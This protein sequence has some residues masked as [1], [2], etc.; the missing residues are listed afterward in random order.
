MRCRT[1]RKAVTGFLFLFCTAS[2]VTASMVRADVELPSVIGDNMVLQRGQPLPVW[3]WAKPGEMIAVTFAGQSVATKTDKN[4]RWQVTLAKI[5]A[6]GPLQMAITSQSG[7]KV[8][9]KNILAGEVWVCSGQSNMEWPLSRA[10]DGRQEI[11]AAKFPKMRLFQIPKVR[12]D[13]PETNCPGQWK[14]CTPAT[15]AGF[16][17]VGYFFGRKLHEDLDV[18][19]GLIQSAWG[20]TPAELWT[21]REVLEADPA[22]K[23]LAGRGSKLYNAMIAPLIPFSIRGAVWYQGEANCSRAYQYRTLLPA[24]IKNWRDD[25]KRGDFPFGIV[26]LAPFRY[27]RLD[28]ACC[29]ELWEAQLMTVKNVPHTGLAV[30]VDIGNVRNI[31]PANKQDVGHRLAL[32]A[33]A[34]TYGKKD[35]VFSGPI[36]KSMTV[37]GRKIRLSFDHTGGGLSTLDGKPPSHF[38]IAGADEKFHPATAAI[39]GPTIVVSCDAVAKPVA[40]RY[41]W[42]DDAQPNLSNKAGLPASP[43][44]TDQWKGVTQPQQ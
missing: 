21:R 14:E 19:V 8:V 17:A 34:E 23:D 1:F 26:Q 24:M 28:P 39:D 6:G 29:A 31:H 30:T 9:L 25:W 20:G 3:G 22:L 27:R 36:Y 7:G 37:E 10:K 15:A 40:V 2:M 13:K 18:P 11:A 42:R 32:W 33:L 5:E 38:T 4:G 43:F 41:A 44:R 16:S 35:L 12:S